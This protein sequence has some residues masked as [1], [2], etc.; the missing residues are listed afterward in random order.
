MPTWT[1]FSSGS[2][3]DAARW[4]GGVPDSVGAVAN[5]TAASGSGLGAALITL[6]QGI[7]TVGTLNIVTGPNYAY[8]FL[9]DVGVTNA[10]LRF[11]NGG[12]PAFL[13]VDTNGSTN[14]SDMRD[15]N[16]FKIEIVSDLI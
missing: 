15:Q 4:T 8:D 3:Q 16:G 11:Q 12:A 13:N 5:F 7:T 2:W 1:N 9:G 14:T 6:S 10:T